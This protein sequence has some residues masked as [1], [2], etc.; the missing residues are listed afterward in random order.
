MEPHRGRFAIL[1]AT[2]VALVAGCEPAGLAGEKTS[3][4][5]S[6]AE[7]VRTADVSILFVGNSHTTMHDLPKLI[8][9]MLRFRQPK[10]T[11]YSQVFEVGFLEDAVQDGR[12]KKLI[13]SAPW[14]FL[15][16]QAQK[17]SRSGRF[18]YSTAEGIELAKLGKARGSTVCFYSE[19][20]VKGVAGHGARIEKIYGKMAAASAAQVAPVGRAWELALSKQAKLELYSEDGNHQSALGA[21][22]TACV[23][24]AKIT[25]EDSST[26]AAFPYR[27]SKADRKLLAEQ[28]ARAIAETKK[29]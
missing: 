5:I 24:F 6:E 16:L 21:F 17:E 29:Q 7:K 2:L 25:G 8:G 1:L 26:L 22:L 18:E 11:Y 15:V 3:V 12:C 28:A 13:E 9:E 27:A 20:G 14:K 23:L 4:S 10:K 19:W